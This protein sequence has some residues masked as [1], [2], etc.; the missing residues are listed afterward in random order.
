MDAKRLED[1]I[2]RFVSDGWN[3]RTK[4]V[5]GH[6]YITRRKGQTERG[7]GPYE[8]KLWK[9]IMDLREQAKT[10]KYSLAVL[11][12]E[13]AT[14]TRART[15]ELDHRLSMDRGTTM[16]MSCLYKDREG[17][18]VYWNWKEKPGFFKIVDD[19]AWIGLYVKKNI[20]SEEEINEKW[21]FQAS[22][23]FCSKCTAY[24]SRSMIEKNSCA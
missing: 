2:R 8:A 12:P 19:I 22:P 16:M 23:W 17:H 21:V 24:L 5:K 1:E 7:V 15:Q 6:L 9:L 20:S 11:E 13:E 3:F 10:G 14:L 18:C 4:T